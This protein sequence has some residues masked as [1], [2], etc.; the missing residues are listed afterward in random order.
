MEH[1]RYIVCLHVESPA[2]MGLPKNEVPR[3]PMNYHTV[4]YQ[5][6]HLEYKK[7]FRHIHVIPQL[8]AKHM[9]T[10]D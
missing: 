10:P 1:L 7:M 9:P 3:I 6:Y 8:M 4:P 5:N 2:N